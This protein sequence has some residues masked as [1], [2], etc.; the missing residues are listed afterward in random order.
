MVFL[1]GDLIVDLVFVVLKRE[2]RRAG[3]S[4]SCL[5]RVSDAVQVF[6]FRVLTFGREGECKRL[7]DAT[8]LSRARF[9]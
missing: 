5:E 4:V 7:A 9:S 2:K 1:L 3:G 8:K 6:E